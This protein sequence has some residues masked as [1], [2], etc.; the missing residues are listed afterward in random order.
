MEL[1]TVGIKKKRVTTNMQID[2]ILEELFKT[3]EGYKLYNKSL[4]Q[5]DIAN[6]SEITYMAQLNGQLKEIR[7]LL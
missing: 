5:L 6:V 1:D 3:N 4:E 2:K 7:K